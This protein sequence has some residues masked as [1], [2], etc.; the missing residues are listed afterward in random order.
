MRAWPLLLCMLSLAF[1][2]DN[3]TNARLASRIKAAMREIEGVLS[4]IAAIELVPAVAPAKPR[5]LLKAAAE[6]PMFR[7]ALSTSETTPP[8]ADPSRRL[9]ELPETTPPQPARRELEPPETT[10]T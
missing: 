1:A 5:R 10:A 7:P 6:E 8:P 4:D 3:A 9:L 2:A